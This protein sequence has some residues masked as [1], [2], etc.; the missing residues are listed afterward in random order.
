MRSAL[1]A[2]AKAAQQTE[3]RG[4]IGL[5]PFGGDLREN[6]LHGAQLLRLVVDDEVALVTELLDVLAQNPDAQRV[7]GADGGSNVERRGSRARII[8]SVFGVRSRLLL[9]DQLV[10]PLLHLA[11]GLVGEGDAEDVAG[12]DPA[13][14]HVRDAKSNHPGLAGS[15][16]G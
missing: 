14:N 4:R 12:G 13:I 9:G 11:R 7:E 6:L 10:D 2:I 3:D 16:A 8:A 5:L 1:A 15:G